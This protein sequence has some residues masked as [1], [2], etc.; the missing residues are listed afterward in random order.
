MLEQLVEVARSHSDTLNRLEEQERSRKAFIQK[1][2]D[3]TT[4]LEQDRER[5]VHETLQA[6]Q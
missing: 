5:L 2:N 1:S 3:L 6:S 4:L